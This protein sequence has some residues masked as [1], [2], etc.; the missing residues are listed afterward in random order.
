MFVKKFLKINELAWNE[1]QSLCHCFKIS[2]RL[3]RFLE[4]KVIL[5]RL[6]AIIPQTR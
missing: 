6:D 3:Q 4:L 5:G 2:P 1:H